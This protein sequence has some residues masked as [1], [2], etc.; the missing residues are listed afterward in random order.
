MSSAENFT[1]SAKCYLQ[2]YSISQLDMNKAEITVNYS[3]TK[4]ELNISTDTKKVLNDINILTYFVIIH[5]SENQKS[6]IFR[7]F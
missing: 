6:R 2:Q 5:K 1:Q 7:A 3:K 4:N